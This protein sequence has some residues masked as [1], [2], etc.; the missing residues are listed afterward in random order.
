V[1]AQ[2]AWQEIPVYSRNCCGGLPPSM[3]SAQQ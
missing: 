2:D 1:L 3:K